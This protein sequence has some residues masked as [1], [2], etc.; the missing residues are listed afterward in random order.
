MATR[1]FKFLTREQRI[2]RRHGKLEPEVTYH[3]ENN[4]PLVI[5]DP[6]NDELPETKVEAEVEEKPK[7]KKATKKKAVKK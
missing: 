1:I 4:E 5:V 2:A 6:S 7:A 3:D